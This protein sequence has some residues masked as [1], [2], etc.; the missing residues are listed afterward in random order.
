MIENEQLIER[1]V[2]GQL[3]EAEAIAF[4]EYFVERPD[5]VGQIEAAQHLHSGL[6]E[7]NSDFK[8][9]PKNRN[10][11]TSL[12]DLFKWLRAPLPVYVLAAPLAVATVMLTQSTDIARPK[13]QLVHFTTQLQRGMES[14]PNLSIID[15]TSDSVV[16]IKVS[17]VRHKYYR[18]RL[19]NAEDT[20]VWRSEKFIAGGMNEIMVLIPAGSIAKSSY[21]LSVVAITANGDE[22]EVEFCHFAESC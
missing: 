14:V 6:Q 18:M 22:L 4:E 8:E 21:G 15:E 12:G 2:L 9:K 16:L 7:Q 19:I 17:K 20:I 5:L 10:K 13:I 3:N 11:H 1:Y